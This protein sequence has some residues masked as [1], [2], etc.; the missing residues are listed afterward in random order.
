MEAILLRPG[1]ERMQ[2]KDA[3]EELI[4][5][6]LVEIRIAKAD[7]ASFLVLPLAAMLY[8]RRKLDVSPLKAAVEADRELLLL[9]GATSDSDLRLGLK[10]RV[11][12][13]VRAIAERVDRHQDVLDDYVDVIKFLARRYTPAWLLLAGMLEERGTRSDWLAASQAIES[14]LQEP[15]EEI[16]RS[17]AWER[18]ETL[19]KRLGDT[20]LELASLVER[21]S[22]KRTPFEVI[23]RAANRVNALLSE[24]PHA[25]DRDEKRILVRRLIEV[26]DGR[27]GEADGTDLS[28]LAWLYLRV[29]DVA[30]ARRIVTVGLES[31][32]QNRYLQRLDAHIQTWV[33]EDHYLRR[34]E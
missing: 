33:P 31:E 3:I 5:S 24:D 4:R 26:F 22:V 17:D 20:Q 10:P 14:Y 8:G 25:V 30:N 15:G 27:V 29:K 7:D 23:S 11:E 28:R 21:A 1:N 32:P 18:Q 13:F 2:V 6:S 9:F 12:R 16:D 34:N 19:A